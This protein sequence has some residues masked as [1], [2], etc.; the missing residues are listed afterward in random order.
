M[1]A[2]LS[3]TPGH[4][5]W[6][7][8][9]RGDDGTWCEART[10]AD[11][12][13]AGVEH[14]RFTWIDLTDPGPDDL[15]LLRQRFAFHRLSIEDVLHR[16]QRAKLDAYETY[17]FFVL[18][19]SPAAGSLDD[20]MNELNVFLGDRYVVTVHSA[21]LTEIGQARRRWREA[22]ADSKSSDQDAVGQ[23][24]EIALYV[25]LDTIVDGYFPLIDEIAEDVAEIEDHIFATPM[26]RGIIRRLLHTRKRL[27]TFRRLV[28]GERDI[29][30]TLTR[31]EL[32]LDHKGH[33]AYFLDVYDH[34]VRVIESIDIY[35]DMTASALDAHLSMTSFRLNETVRRMT[36][37]ATILAT[38]TIITGFYGM[39]FKFMPE[40]D[41][42]AG[43][44]FVIGLMLVSALGLAYWFRR[45]DWL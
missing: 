28:G 13:K 25:L 11:L 31:R 24:G 39:N 27:L 37:L 34:L 7:I 12:P 5:R 15:E 20:G 41:W 10:P 23:P 36:A 16:N 2:M 38:E 3:V 42:P 18:Y 21:P 30:N 22:L 44:P 9:V 43:E 40:L 32:D 8:L 33:S 29:V 26:P 14:A 17:Q 4:E 1:W 19:A 45:I 35:R 6:H